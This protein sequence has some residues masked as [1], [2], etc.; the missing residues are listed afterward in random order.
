MLKASGKAMGRTLSDR[1]L[2]LFAQATS[3]VAPWRRWP[4]VIA[5][6]TLEGLRAKMRWKN[7]FDT[8]RTAPAV[9]PAPVARTDEPA[10]FERTADGSYNDTKSPW[11]GMAGARFGR[12]LPI[13]RTYGATPEALLEPNPRLIS[14]VLLARRDGKVVE[15]ERLNLL[16]AAWLQFMVHDW[17][18]HGPSEREHPYEVPLPAQDD[19]PQNPMRIRRS[20]RAPTDAADADQPTCYVNTETH[21]W[22]ASQIYGSSLKQQRFVRMDPAT[23][24]VRADGKLHLTPDGHLPLARA[25]QQHGDPTGA[26]FPDQE[27][28]GVTGN[29]WIGLSLFHTLFA[30]EHNAIVD[31]LRIDY[32]AADGEWL[33]QK[34]RLA[35]AALLAKIHTTEW[36][37]AMMNSPIGRLVLRS[38][39]WGL[40]GER[41]TRGYGRFDASE[42]L[43]GILG[44]PTN[45]H[46][47]P[48][49]MTEEFVAAYR[50]HSLLPDGLSFRRAK[51]NA[52]VLEAPLRD[53]IR[54][55][56]PEVYRKVGGLADVAYSL[57]T[58]HPG[59]LVL[60]NYPDTLRR[61][62]VDPK[63]PERVSDVAATDILR[64]RERGVPR[65]CE[66]RRLVGMKAPRSF[67]ELTANPE[68]RDEL[69][70]VYARVEDVDLLVGTL[71]EDAPPGFGFSDTA[72]RIF[73]LM[74]S[75]RLKSDRFYTCDF[76][77]EVYTP[78]GFGWVRDNS[79][80]SVFQR[81][82][83]E[84]EPH[85]A[86]LR[87]LFFPWTPGPL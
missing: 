41:F 77:A 6:V 22:D 76:R 4:F 29:W 12:N 30:R 67:E 81:H 42:A 50:M 18:S 45:H 11:M 78:A 20:R 24:E 59:A 86:K 28:A 19:W 40:A 46:A 7:L 55:H 71:C 14:N 1:G 27:L 21:W 85:F 47:A 25:L 62:P 26:K 70:S 38:N 64:D 52:V 87:N 49:A 5:L 31:R 34:S 61:L 33:F 60:H 44:S 51:D 73:L 57:A 3:A 13:Q 2:A 80:R 66:F 10:S 15:V 82:C 56:V 65:Y 83:P 39:W 43:S 53:V 16:A 68:W 63:A 35:N 36:T 32:P 8:Q 58:L 72:F 9:G 74:A 54:S 75:R 48:F 37:P 17:L 69:K 79:L 23:G 84:L